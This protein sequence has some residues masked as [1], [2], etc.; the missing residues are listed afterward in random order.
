MLRAP[1]VDEVIFRPADDVLPVVAAKQV[2]HSL[3][4]T[5]PSRSTSAIQTSAIPIVRPEDEA[6]SVPIPEAGFDLRGVVGAAPVFAGERQVAKVVQPDA[7]IIGRHQ[8]LK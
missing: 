7:R 2:Q 8:Y 6:Q 5:H 1:D 4:N 3:T